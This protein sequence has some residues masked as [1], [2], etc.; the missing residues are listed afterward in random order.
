MRALIIVD[1]QNDFC[2]GGAL[3]VDGGV[4]VAQA[5]SRYIRSVTD[6]DYVVATR[7]AHVD[8]GEHF[9]DAPDYA[10]SWPPHCLAGTWGAELRPELDSSRIDAVFDKGAYAPGYSG[11]DGID[12]AGTALGDWLRGH[13][14]DAV[15]I[16]GVATDYCIRRT[17][18]DAV[19]A[20]FATTV[21]ANMTAGVA[22]GS[23]A[24]ALTAMR[25][26]GITVVEA[27]R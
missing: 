25:S 5:I 11:F 21:L 3:A 18:E 4:A 23:T 7:D 1:V 14:V 6:Y 9:A 27:A 2:E 17:A 19:A 16:V 8:P 12:S 26:A 10:T 22:A 13:C 20:G 24:T 15:D